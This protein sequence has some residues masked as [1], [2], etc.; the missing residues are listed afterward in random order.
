[1][2]RRR[3]RSGPRHGGTSS[4]TARIWSPAEYTPGTIANKLTVL[5]RFYAA[6]QA[7]GFRPDNPVVGVRAPREKKAVEDFGYPSEVELTP[8]PRR[9]IA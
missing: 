8:V 9:P 3:G 4:A 5:R 1:M 7:A 6:A 2:R